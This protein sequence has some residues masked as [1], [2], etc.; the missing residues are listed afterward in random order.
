MRYIST[1]KAV[2]YGNSTYVLLEKSW[3]IVPG[4]MVQIEVE[5]ID[6]RAGPEAED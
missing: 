3:G 4:D 1:R 5:K 2:Q 6:P